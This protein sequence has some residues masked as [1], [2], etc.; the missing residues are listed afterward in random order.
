MHNSWWQKFIIKALIAVFICWTILPVIQAVDFDAARVEAADANSTPDPLQKAANSVYAAADSLKLLSESSNSTKKAKIGLNAYDYSELKKYSTLYLA[1]KNDPALMAQYIK[2][3]TIPDDLKQK[4]DIRLDPSNF[5]IR[6][7]KSLIYLVTP[8]DRGGAGREW[9]KVDSITRGYTSQATSSII[10]TGG[11]DEEKIK[12]MPASVQKNV[13]SPHAKPDGQ[14]ADITEIDYL[15][16]TKFTYED[17]K[18][19]DKTKLDPMPIKVAWQTDKGTGKAS[20]ATK[21]MGLSLDKVANNMRNQALTSSLNQWLSEQGIDIG[22]FS[23][24]NIGANLGDNLANIMHNVGNAWYKENWQMPANANISSNLGNTGYNFGQ[25][26]LQEMS[27][28]IIPAAGFS[29]STPQ[30]MYQSAGREIVAQNMAL[31]AYSFIDG[32]NSSK[33][34][35]SSVGQRKMEDALGL[36]EGSLRGLTNSDADQLKIKIG[37]GFIEKQLSLNA[38]DFSGNSVA[39]IQGK[40]GQ[41]KFQELS[42]NA[43]DI[44]GLLYLDSGQFGQL[45]NDPQALKKAVGEKVI[46]NKILVYEI[47]PDG[48]NRRDEAFGISDPDNKN[49]V[50]RFIGGD[51][52]VFYDMGIVVISHT[53]SNDANE[54][55]LIQSW[56]KTG[57][58]ET[59]PDKNDLPKF[60]EQILA[61]KVNLKANDLWRIF[62]NN[63]AYEVFQRVGQIAWTSILAPDQDKTANSKVNGTPNDDFYH[64]HFKDIKDLATKIN[65]QSKN[66]SVKSLAQDIYNLALE[67]ETYGNTDANDLTKTINS[68]VLYPLAEK[69][70]DSINTILGKLSEISKLENTGDIQSL[71]NKSYEVIEG[72]N[73]VDLSKLSQ[74]NLNFPT[75]PYYLEPTYQN[76]LS[77]AFQGKKNF[78]DFVRE[79]GLVYWGTTMGL[80]NPT[81]LITAWQQISS[82]INSN[83]IDILKGIINT[84][85]LQNITDQ[86]NN[87]MG[88]APW[89]SSSDYYKITANDALG[90]LVGQPLS[91]IKKLGSYAMDQALYFSP[92]YGS[93]EI[94]SGSVSLDAANQFAAINKFGHRILGLIEDVPTTGN[95]I[96]NLTKLFFAESLGLPKEFAFDFNNY[97]KDD[98]NKVNVLMAL[99]IVPPT[100]LGSDWAGIVNWAKTTQ[101]WNEQQGLISATANIFKAPVD[102]MNN[103][104]SS[105][106]SGNF[107]S[108]VSNLGQIYGNV[109]SVISSFITPDKINEGIGLTDSVQKGLGFLQYTSAQVKTLKDAFDSGDSGKFL[110][111]FAQAATN[112]LMINNYA[113]DSGY[114]GNPQTTQELANIS[115][116]LSTLSAAGNNKKATNEGYAQFALNTL[117]TYYPK[118]LDLAEK[119][120]LIYQTL[121]SIVQA[122]SEADRTANAQTISSNMAA[123]LTQNMPASMI[124]QEQIQPDIQTLIT[125]GQV[126]GA[127]GA[128]AIAQQLHEYKDAMDKNGISLDGQ[129]GQGTSLQD[130]G[131]TQP[132][133]AGAKEGAFGLTSTTKDRTYIET[134]SSAF[135]QYAQQKG[136]ETEQL[137]QREF[138]KSEYR[139]KQQDEQQ[140]LYFE[141]ILFAQIDAKLGIPLTQV[142]FRGTDD[143][144]K[145]ALRQYLMYSV[146]KGTN[147]PAWGAASID[148]LSRALFNHEKID[149]RQLGSVI[150]MALGSILKLD[151]IP[152]GLGQGFAD[153]VMNG[154]TTQLTNSLKDGAVLYGTTFIDKSLGLPGGTT[155]SM[156]N[157]WNTYQGALSTYHGAVDS[158]LN[159]YAD[160][161]TSELL[162]KTAPG[163]ISPDKIAGMKSSV[164]SLETARDAALKNLQMTN[165][166]IAITVVNML[167]GPTFSKMEQQMGLPSGTMSL[168]ASAIIYSTIGGLSLSAVAALLWPAAALMLLG[169]LFGGRGG[170][171]GGLL[172]GNRNQKSQKIEVVYS[173]CGYYPGF[174]QKP[175][176]NIE[177]K[178]PAEFHGE[179]KELF[180]K[181]AMAAANHVIENRLLY[182][183]LTMGSKMKDSMMVPSRIETL[184]IEH[185]KYLSSVADKVYANGEVGGMQKYIDQGASRGISY[186]KSLWDRVMYWY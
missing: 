127:T 118:A 50:N 79:I 11:A 156:Y 71:K 82:N 183:L 142:M 46:A 106:S 76:N 23:D 105:I 35:I 29:G 34:L 21:T 122:T 138:L 72:V 86:A 88:L 1:L 186:N 139:R 137:K 172:G 134:T 97:I 83:P 74:N 9:I 104:I 129:S 114:V 124:T 64:N 58:I 30:E 182:N 170:I 155:Y 14:A 44:D 13:I 68:N 66:Q 52:E 135:E 126:A 69:S 148:M 107:D 39:E 96:D 101:P 85:Y 173:A 119:G 37:Q 180:M 152:P 33:D 81:D 70:K 171:L 43:I 90:L 115:T 154:N 167:L 94:A 103:L 4:F 54:I 2:T 121:Q 163:L 131:A 6:I 92:G 80:E 51:A 24:G 27:N 60:D 150:D 136:K 128:M 177:P 63:Q 169:A 178:C 5:D 176:A 8:K 36:S 55:K 41:P 89:G 130:Y 42:A 49:L 18:L 99:G 181:G 147:L 158:V 168:I 140:K 112:F 141:N 32:G 166:N 174:D 87:G 98:R 143:Q 175:P 179:T 47:G 161:N 125:G 15:R 3:S 38:G 100:N 165:A 144:K 113:H 26:L 145:E 56:L 25:S 19:V 162:N 95:M 7:L 146:L 78:N 108:A 102:S 31:P 160:L 16:G 116:M 59:D 132:T 40:I 65:S 53:L 109:K 164:V 57:K 20:D 123:G 117:G 48:S 77:Q 120:L 10:K 157:M 67:M 110:S 75:K 153:W 185:V 133:Y 61:G 62:I 159:T 91:F 28:G 111:S 17:G 151:Y 73:L 149:S 12:K 45:I 93:R 22:Q 84:D 184:K